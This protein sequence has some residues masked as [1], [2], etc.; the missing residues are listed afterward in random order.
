MRFN[1]TALVI[2]IYVLLLSF[3]STVTGRGKKATHHLLCCSTKLYA[4][5]IR[6]IRERIF[7]SSFL[8]MG[9]VCFHLAI[10]PFPT[11]CSLVNY[12]CV[13]YLSSENVCYYKHLT[14]VTNSERIRL[15]YCS[16]PTAYFC[17]NTVSYLNDFCV[18]KFT[19][20]QNRT[21]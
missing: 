1:Q 21:S 20:T 6:R 14:T 8:F 5:P 19:L 2:V 11:T 10:I 7:F 17:S 9:L 16:L 13:A 15:L 18:R 4:F 3:A 12:I